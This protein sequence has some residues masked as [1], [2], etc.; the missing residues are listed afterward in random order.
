VAQGVGERG[1]DAL[2]GRVLQVPGERVQERPMTGQTGGQ[3]GAVVVDDPPE[4]FERVAVG[5][6][7]SSCSAA[8]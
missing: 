8:P 6:A 7:S 2:V 3:A 1:L 4:P 5:M